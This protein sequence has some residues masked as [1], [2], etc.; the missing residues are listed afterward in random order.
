MD[1][2]VLVIGAGPGGCAA[3]YA[4]RRAGWRV[5]LAER[6][7]YPVDKLCGEFLSPEG[8]ESLGRMGLGAALTE[9]PRIGEVLVSS[10]SGNTWKAPL[11]A[12]GLGISRRR[13]DLLLLERCAATGVE[14]V[15][16]VRVSQVEGDLE[17]G[18]TASGRGM[19]AQARLVVGAWGRQQQG[20]RSGLMALKVH[21]RG[22]L[23]GIELHSFPGGYAGL[24]QVGEN[25]VNLCLLTRVDAFRQAGGDCRQFSAEIMAKN[26]LLAGRLEALNPGWDQALAAANLSFGAS[27]CQVGGILLVG[28]AAGSIAP[29]CGDGMAMALRAGELLAPLVDR[30]LKGALGALK[31]EYAH[32][33]QED[34]RLRLQVG[35]LLHQALLRPGWARAA[36]GIL[37]RF[38]ALGQG[39]F[40]WTRGGQG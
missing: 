12:P 28:D 27:S 2:D 8:V 39:L 35:G 3:A 21:A 33:W 25:E 16:G 9:F 6:R 4:L 20:R 34:F 30:F 17:K 19:Q 31:A 7:R 23:R 37:R 22:R 36:V 15:Q 32:C 1:C 29:L 13:L 38:P 26:S 24:C 5:L 14:V 40:R 11:P 18:F 10:P